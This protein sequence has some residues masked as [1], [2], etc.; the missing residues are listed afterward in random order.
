MH[1][2]I[3]FAI[4]SVLMVA[5][6]GIAANENDYKVRF[7][8]DLFGSATTGNGGGES[9]GGESGGGSNAAEEIGG[10][11]FIQ[12]SNAWENFMN[13]NGLSSAIPPDGNSDGYPDWASGVDFTSLEVGE[14]SEGGEGGESIYLDTLPSERYPIYE[15]YT[16]IVLA[17]YQFTN[18]S[19][20]S[21]FSGNKLILY[22]DNALVDISALS[23]FNGSILS[24]GSSSLT[25]LSPLNTAIVDSVLEI[26][27]TGNYTTL[28]SSSAYVCQPENAGIF[29]S[30]YASFFT[31]LTQA[32]ACDC[33]DSNS[34]QICD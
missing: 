13:A 33:S 21:G 17:S 9:G 25:D 6:F 32:E 5:S 3:K 15:D 19:P 11:V 27:D 26:S 4:A 22:A 1:S 24:L 29:Q 18:V 10:S 2:K 34:D 23:D 16:D 30:Y 20:L 8:M 14:G 12:R 31:P 7:N 28:I